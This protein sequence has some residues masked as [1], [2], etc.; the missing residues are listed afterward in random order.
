[1]GTPR[2]RS[3]V[4]PRG[5]RRPPPIGHT[6]GRSS[7][8]QQLEDRP[9]LRSPV[10]CGAA[11]RALRAARCRA[12][13]STWSSAAAS[14]NSALA[15]VS[16]PGVVSTTMC[17][18]RSSGERR[19]S[20][21]PSVSSSLSRPTRFVRSI[22]GA[23]PAPAACCRRGRAAPSASAGAAGACRA[24][25]AWT[26]CGCACGG[27]GGPAAHRAVRG[28]VDDG[29]RGDGLR[30]LGAAPTIDVLQLIDITQTNYEGPR[31]SHLLHIDS[32]IQG[33]R[34]ITRRLTARAAEPGGRPIPTGRSVP[35]PGRAS[36]PAPRRRR[37]A[38]ARMV[39]P[40]QR[41]PGAG[42]SWELT[43]ELIGEIAAPT[44][45]SRPAALQL[46]RAERGQVVGRP[47]DRARAR[48]TTP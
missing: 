39:P 24:R 25:R 13:P 18:R 38:V 19:R 29:E 26:R 7:R 6:P 9:A 28:L 48:R 4:R 22:A 41:T 42:G 20:I 16:R 31:M 40:E 37:P 11:G 21:S 45:S 30:S 1:M 3:A 10:A 27:P 33:E 47:P 44:R 12:R 8:I 17:R 35:R 5:S 36:A 23:S 14:A 46:R 34:S 2:L 32:S 15:S 43:A